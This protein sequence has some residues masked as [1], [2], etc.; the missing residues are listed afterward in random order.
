MVTEIILIISRFILLTFNLTALYS[1][2]ISRDDFDNDDD[3]EDEGGLTPVV[4]DIAC[5][6]GLLFMKV[7]RANG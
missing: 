3:D 5:T 6:S 4:G 2:S 1:F 7:S